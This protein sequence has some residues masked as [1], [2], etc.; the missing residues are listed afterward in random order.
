MKKLSKRFYIVAYGNDSYYVFY[1]E[2][3]IRRFLFV[4]YIHHHGLSFVAFKTKYE[5][6]MFRND[7]INEYK[8]G[9]KMLK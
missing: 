4:R 7:R 6:Q 1:T 5:A 9:L 3:V 2:W 8:H